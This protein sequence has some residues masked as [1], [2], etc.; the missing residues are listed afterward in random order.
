M[1][2][3]MGTKSGYRLYCTS[4]RM[5]TRR[6]AEARKAADQF[7]RDAVNKRVL[8]FKGPAQPSPMLGDALN[9]IYLEVRCLE[10]QVG[11]PHGKG[12]MRKTLTSLVLLA[13]LAG[14]VCVT[15]AEH[16]TPEE[17]A[18]YSLQSQNVQEFANQ[19]KQFVG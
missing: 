17:L 3:T 12:T 11:F 16:I 19:F 8:A 4:V 13:A 1:V 9:Y 10:H 2:P 5:A 6:A 15:H 14:G 7:A 18:I